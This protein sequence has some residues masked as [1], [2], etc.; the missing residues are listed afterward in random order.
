MPLEEEQLIRG[1]LGDR[2]RLLAYLRSIVADRHAAEDLYQELTVRALRE[3]E[4]LADLGHLAAW[5]R[6]TARNLAVDYLR[7]QKSRPVSLDQ[8]T[9]EL[10]E[11]HWSRPSHGDSGRLDALRRCLEKL[12]Q[13][14]RQLVEF[15]YAAQLSAA[16]IAA[17]IDRKI[18][19]VYTSLSRIYRML[20]E[21]VD[22]R[23]PKEGA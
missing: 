13:H 21:C 14:A 17:K 12:S 6:T 19:T 16:Q 7:R 23:I 20:A 18:D 22:Q 11:S 2:I 15:R 8:A 4:K 5:C 3:R 1:V 9:L 10:L